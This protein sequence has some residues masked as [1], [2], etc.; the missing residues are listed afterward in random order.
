MNSNSPKHK[1]ALIGFSLSAVSILFSIILLAISSKIYYSE[2]QASLFMG[3]AL[4]TSLPGIIC[5]AIAKLKKNTE[6]FSI[7][8]IVVGIVS[9][10]L[11][12]GASASGSW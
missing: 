4:Y 9:V 11:I 8:G 2:N 1:L 12:I 7:L 10:I 3:L 6:F 5:S